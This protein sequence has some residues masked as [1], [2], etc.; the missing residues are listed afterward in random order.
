M[1]RIADA[2]VRVFEVPR[3]CCAKICSTVI[4]TDDEMHG[5]E[6]VLRLDDVGHVFNHEHCRWLVTL[7][8]LERS[9]KS[10]DGMAEV[11]VEYPDVH[12]LIKSK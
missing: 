4:F 5:R 10:A 2:L 3:E 9:R 11:A 6:Q 8:A 7:V 12:L 1:L